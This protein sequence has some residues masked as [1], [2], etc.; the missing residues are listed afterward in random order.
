M[1]ETVDQMACLNLQFIWM[2]WFGPLSLISDGSVFDEIL[3]KDSD[4]RPY[5]V[6]LKRF[7]QIPRSSRPKTRLSSPPPERCGCPN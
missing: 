6:P 1:P 7:C 3:A 4:V 5:P 2:F